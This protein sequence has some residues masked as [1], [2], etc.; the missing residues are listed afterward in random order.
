M[1]DEKPLLIFVCTSNVC[2][3]PMAEGFSRKF[4]I[5]KLNDK[6]HICSRALTNQ[7][8]PEGSPA[9]MNSI[10][11]MKNDFHIDIANHESKL[12]DDND[13]AKAYKI[14]G[15]SQSHYSEICKRYPSHAN[16]VTKLEKDIPDPWHQPIQVYQIT[17]T[18]M[19]EQINSIMDKMS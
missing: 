19:N 14:I 12:L 18:L 17:A 4:N 15:V 3:S 11:T 13:V 7:Y 6:Y 5:D 10:E 9:S 16:K 2:R 8:E 1:N